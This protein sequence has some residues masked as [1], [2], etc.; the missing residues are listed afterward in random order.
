MDWARSA[1]TSANWAATEPNGLEVA[2]RFA[3]AACRD[4]CWTALSRPAWR[5]WRVCPG[6]PF[7]SVRTWDEVALDCSART[8][9]CAARE[10]LEL[11]S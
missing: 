11:A 8:V 9:P 4:V 7:N 3:R 2:V 5:P 6:R 10:R 1:K